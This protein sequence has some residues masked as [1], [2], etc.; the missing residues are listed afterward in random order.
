MRSGTATTAGSSEVFLGRE[1]FKNEETCDEGE[2]DRVR[3]IG[4]LRALEG[5]WRFTSLV[6]EGADVPAA[7]L[8]RSRILMDGDRFRT[9]SDAAT[10]EGVFAIDADEGIIERIEPRQQCIARDVKGRRH[11]LV[12]NVDQ[13]RDLAKTLG[14]NSIAL[15]RGHGGWKLPH[16][17]E[18]Q[19]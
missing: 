11:V 7:A 15:M 3:Q 10:Y 5:E 1:R 8:E 6:L 14:G 16:D 18:E 9:E 13:G 12:A 4:F 19:P 2:R 17:M